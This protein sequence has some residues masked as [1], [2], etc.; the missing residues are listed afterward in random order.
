MTIF[1]KRLLYL[2]L[3]FTIKSYAIN[4]NIISKDMM[5]YDSTVYVWIENYTDKTIYY[6]GTDGYQAWHPKGL[7]PHNIL[8]QEKANRGNPA[9]LNTPYEIQKLDFKK[10]DY[11]FAIRYLPGYYNFDDSLNT[12]FFLIN[13]NNCRSYFKLHFW[14]GLTEINAYDLMGNIGYSLAAV[15]F[16]WFTP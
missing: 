12:N 11:A 9:F 14:N 3:I 1:N 5:S 15:G 8:P 6:D 13:N 4:A 2:L 7:Q 16:F 10:G